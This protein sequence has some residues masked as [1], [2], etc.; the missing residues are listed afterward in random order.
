M[1]LS[2]KREQLSKGMEYYGISEN[3]NWKIECDL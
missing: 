3:K 2:P 1:K